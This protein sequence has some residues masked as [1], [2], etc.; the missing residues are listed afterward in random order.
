MKAGGSNLATVAM[1]L[2]VIGAI[3]WG[4][5]GA[6]DWNLVEAI[7][8]SWDWLVMIIYV[9]VGISGVWGLVELLKNGGK[10]K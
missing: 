10:M 9:L 4:L 7:F 1:W 3:N 5:V 2:V 8:G 6:F